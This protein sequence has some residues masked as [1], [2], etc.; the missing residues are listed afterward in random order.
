M[1]KFD[2]RTTILISLID[3]LFSCLQ[4]NDV[5][6]DVTV[7]RLLK[8]NYVERHRPVHA[9]EEGMQTVIF[10]FS[11]SYCCSPISCNLLC[12]SC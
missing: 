7:D 12:A 3:L 2:L 6:K 1:D 11:L 5:V 10:L 4:E 9:V 8:S